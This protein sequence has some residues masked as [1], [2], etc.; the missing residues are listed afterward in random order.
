M[1]IGRG[2]K[3]ALGVQIFLALALVASDV[4]RTWLSKIS[5][6]SD[7]PS[8]PASPGDQ[9]RR[10]DPSRVQPD[11]TDRLTPPS[12]DLPNRLPPRLDFSITEVEGTAVLLIVGSITSGDSER[13]ESFLADLEPRPEIIALN[14][15]GGIVREALEVGRV[16]RSAE[17]N[18]V[19]L[20]G[21][22][23]LSACPYVFAAGRERRVSRRGAL[24]LHQHYYEAP[25]YMPVFLAVEGIQRGQGLTLEYLIEMG[26]DPTLM[27]Y[28]LRTPPDAIYVMLDN[29]L[30]ETKLATEIVD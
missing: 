24:G 23:C 17:M 25:G 8:G 19:I 2:L 9:V 1:T 28:S 14:S 3:W 5:R 15:P 12:I 10:Y 30:M 22:S 21:M 26:I 20:P 27:L 6:P 16:L 18:T 7:L 29:E 4:D 13:L 11:L